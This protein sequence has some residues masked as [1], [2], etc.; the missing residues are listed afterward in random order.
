[1][2]TRS[3]ASTLRTM[4]QPWFSS[5]SRFATGTTTSVKWIS[6]MRWPANGFGIS[7][8]SMPGV[9]IGTS[10]IVMPSR[11]GDSGSVRTS[12]KHHSAAWA[13]DVQIFWPFTM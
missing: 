3:L 8:T 12:R 5:P 10:R 9:S 6:W 4:P 13:Y 2:P 7:R 1:M 11:F